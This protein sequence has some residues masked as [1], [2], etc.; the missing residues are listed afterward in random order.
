[1][2]ERKP[3]DSAYHKGKTAYS[4]GVDITDNPYKK[5]DKELALLWDSGWH[6]ACKDREEFE[7]KGKQTLM[8]RKEFENNS[9][10]DLEKENNLETH[11]LWHVV[12]FISLVVI[13]F[14][15]SLLLL[16]LLFGWD[17]TVQLFREFVIGTIRLTVFLLSLAIVLLVIV[18]LIS[19]FL[20]GA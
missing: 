20:K 15:W 13:F 8:A 6:K 18:Y 19:A 5:T 2:K 9:K 12:L 16:L 11:P 4:N 17:G 1:M 3:T 10:G 7:N 14:P